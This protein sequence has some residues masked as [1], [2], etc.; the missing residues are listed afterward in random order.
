MRT[1]RPI[2]G[3]AGLTLVVLGLL[4][5]GA[6]ACQLESPHSTLPFLGAS[7]GELPAPLS[8]LIAAPVVLPAPAPLATCAPPAPA[9]TT[10][11]ACAPI[12]GNAGCCYFASREYLAARTTALIDRL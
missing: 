7:S 8:V 10:M 6:L 1:G 9:S 4:S 5:T 2:L 3:V 12:A 11:P